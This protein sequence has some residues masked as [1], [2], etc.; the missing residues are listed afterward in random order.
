MYNVC[1]YP[2]SRDTVT[3]SDES[4][5]NHSEPGELELNP[6]AGSDHD[7]EHGTT[8]EQ[9]ELESEPEI[10][11]DHDGEILISQRSAKR[12]GCI[13]GIESGA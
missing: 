3:A 2:H 12:S 9:D 8:S 4:G 5:D 6:E 10:V 1:I 7:P 13:E 11:S